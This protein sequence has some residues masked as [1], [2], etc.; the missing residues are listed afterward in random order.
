MTSPT[1]SRLPH[2]DAEQVRL[3]K[4]FFWDQAR[5]STGT[6]SRQHVH[7]GGVGF[8]AFNSRKETGKDVIDFILYRQ[9]SG[10]GAP[11]D[12]ALARRYC[13]SQKK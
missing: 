13:R 2:D 9:L 3:K 12:A 7:R 4:K 10:A 8:N 6:G 1:C 5:S 11:V